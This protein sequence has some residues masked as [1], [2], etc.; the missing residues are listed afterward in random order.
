MRATV[1]PNSLLTHTASLVTARSAGP[2]STPTAIRAVTT[3]RRGS[4][5][6]TVPS[7]ALVTQT[8]VR[9]EREGGRPAADLDRAHRAAAFALISVTMPEDGLLAH[10]TPAPQ[11]SSA[12][13]LS[14]RTV[15]VLRP[16][17]GSRRTTA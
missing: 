3:P 17:S 12:G 7:G 14:S 10:T 6:E 16:L 9:A 5:R 8:R 4:I 2:S 11:A 15:A 1:P 13:W